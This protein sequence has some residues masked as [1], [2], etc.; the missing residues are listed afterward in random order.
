MK[1]YGTLIA[2]AVAVVFGI[3]AVV[4]A[5]KWLS[6]QVTDETVIIKEQVPLSQVVI[7]GKDLDMGTLLTEENL[8]IAGWPKANE[9]KG[10]FSKFEDVA[11]RVTVAKVTAGT[12]IVSAGLAAPGSGIGLVAMIDPGMRA[13][14]IRVDE[15]IGVGGFILP[16]TFV[17]VISVETEGK[18]RIA[19]TILKRIEVIAVAQETFVEEGKA[20]LV[21][22]VT[23]EVTPKQ[24][25]TLAST[26]NKNPIHLVLRNPTEEGEKTKV[27]VAPE[28]EKKIVKAVKRT[29]R[30]RPKPTPEPVTYDVLIIRGTKS[31]ENIKLPTSN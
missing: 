23:L 9:P 12:P 15:V 26:I 20:K 21:R 27:V 14:S 29:Y 19:K 1:K 3:I 8:A 10:A 5:N 24:A 11:G 25:E 18:S 28:P 7:A 16:N 2:L 31:V 30:P 4:L 17:D 22:T 13:M 6:S